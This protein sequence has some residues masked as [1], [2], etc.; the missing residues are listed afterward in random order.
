[1]ITSALILASRSP[2]R[3]ELLRSLGIDFSV[4]DI[5]VDETRHPAEAAKDYVTRVAHAKAGAGRAICAD[6]NPVLAAD[7]CVVLDQEIFGKPRDRADGEQMLQR[8]AGRWHEVF[9]G[10]AL[11]GET[12][13]V[14]CVRTRVLFRELTTSEISNYWSSGEPRDKA[15]GYGI[16]GLGGALV[17]RIDGSYS[18]VV[19]L[20]LAETLQ[21][22]NRSGIKHRL[23]GSS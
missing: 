12:N 7:T 13:E 6:T 21:V 11:Q 16:Q 14:V 17:E 3:A 8:L 9:T 22:L 23:S 20:P 10:V 2:R 15:G 4:V 1:M 18:N 19:G 5:A